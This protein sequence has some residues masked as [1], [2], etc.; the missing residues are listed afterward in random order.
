MMWKYSIWLIGVMT[1]AGCT[2]HQTSELVVVRDLTDEHIVGPW[3]LDGQKLGLVT[4]LAHNIHNGSIIRLYSITGSRYNSKSKELRLERAG[5]Y[6]DEDLLAREE[7][8]EE[9][10]TAA[11]TMMAGTVHKDSLPNS[12]IYRR[13]V[14]ALIK[15]SRSR[16]DRRTAIVYSDLGEN[17]L[18]LSAYGTHGREL[19][20][21]ATDSL[22][23]QLKNSVELPSLTGVRVHFIH[24]GGSDQNASTR[25]EVIANIYRELLEAKGA[26]VFI[27]GSF[28][29]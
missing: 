27:S 17:D 19:W 6:L 24:D 23:Q 2:E 14:D 1:I 10:L 20:Q 29:P 16:A 26:S 8:V 15:L 4:G 28:E 7:L 21:S 9:H 22:K 11:V 5:H 12:V 18:F 25:F 3:E 13:V